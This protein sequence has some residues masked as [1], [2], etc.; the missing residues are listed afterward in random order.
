[1]IIKSITK[2]ESEEGRGKAKYP[3][4]STLHTPGHFR[5]RSDFITCMA[6]LS[7]GRAERGGLS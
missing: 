3:D 7:G 5:L 6:R 2:A 1:M 4:I